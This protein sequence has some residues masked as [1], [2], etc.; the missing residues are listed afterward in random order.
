MCYHLYDNAVAISLYPHCC[1][2]VVILEEKRMTRPF[3]GRTQSS[4]SGVHACGSK[5]VFGHIC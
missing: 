5:V 2:Q 4:L 1:K 3:G